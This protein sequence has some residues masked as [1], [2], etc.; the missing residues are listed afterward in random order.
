MQ[1]IKVQDQELGFDEVVDTLSDAIAF[2]D[3]VEKQLDDGF[4]VTDLI[5]IAM[6]YQ[7]LL[8]I[9]N[10]RKLFAAQF[11]DLSAEEAKQVV[12][13]VAERTGKDEGIVREK[14]IQ[15]LRISAR[16]YGLIDYLLK[17]GK[18]ILA[19]AKALAS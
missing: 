1:V 13:Q 18:V 15:A 12:E 10:D 7:G 4:Q 3:L 14:A 16:A 2:I 8:E 9:Y 11:I 19:E 5:T 6:Q 17:E